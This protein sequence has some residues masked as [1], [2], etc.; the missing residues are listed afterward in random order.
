[1]TVPVD[2][3]SKDIS[4]L[5]I[6]LPVQ[7]TELILSS[8]RFCQLRVTSQW[9]LETVKSYVVKHIPIGEDNWR[10]MT[11]PGSSL[12]NGRQFAT[13]VN[14]ME[15]AS[16]FYSLFEMCT[17]LME[18]TIDK[19]LL[20]YVVNVAKKHHMVWASMNV[21]TKFAQDILAKVSTERIW[22]I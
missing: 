4:D 2:D 14:V 11:S 6:A 5:A 21:Q 22:P 3:S 16:D 18:H 15:I 17:W 10:V 13:V 1:M 9:L 20:T 19:T 12:L 8:S 7:L